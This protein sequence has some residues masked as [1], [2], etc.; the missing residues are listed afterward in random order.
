MNARILRLPPVL[1]LLVIIV[2]S[3]GQAWFPLPLRVPSFS[4]GMTAGLIIVIAAV[5]IA[6][7]GLAE[8]KRHRT[9]VEPWQ[10]PS[11]LVTRGVFAFTR[12]PLY[13]S[14]LLILLGIAVMTDSGWFVVAAA[15]L[16]IIL[17][18]AVIRSEER[19]LGEIFGNQYINYKRS[20]RRWL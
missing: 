1:F 11:R 6:G 5:A 16:G 10:R 20:V 7:G 12:N 19:V 4:I 18:R 15:T 9:T 2:A 14:L 17:D 3:T 8:M 13:L